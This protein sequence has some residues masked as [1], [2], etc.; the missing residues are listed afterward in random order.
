MKNLDVIG[1]SKFLS[2]TNIQD[3]IKKTFLDLNKKIDSKVEIK[4][5]TLKDMKKLNLSYRNVD[6]ATD[7]ISFPLKKI[8]GKENL[9]GSIVICEEYMAS[10]GG[11]TVELIKHGILHLLGHDH[12][13][14]PAK[15]TKV[16]SQI[17]HKMI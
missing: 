9:L 13:I 16:A 12:E 1:K 17:N 8:P 5:V 7:V 15:W 2:D 10:V 14:D 3:T 4:F 6:A 11:D